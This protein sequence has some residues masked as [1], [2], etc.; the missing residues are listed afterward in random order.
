MDDD[1]P[2]SAAAGHSG[3]AQQQQL[4][5]SPPAHR[6]HFPAFPY[7]PYDIQQGFMEALY[8]SLERRELGLFESPTGVCQLEVVGSRRACCCSA[9]CG[10]H[11]ALLLPSSPAATQ[12][13]R[14]LP[15]GQARARQSR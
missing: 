7:K 12:R 6:Q 15:D 3:A 5:A 10:W 9:L 11:P 14:F 2:P 13:L 8:E 1:D 4:G